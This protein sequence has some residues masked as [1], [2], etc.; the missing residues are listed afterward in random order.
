MKRSARLVAGSSVELM[1]HEPTSWI[2]SSL[3]FLSATSTL[4]APTAAKDEAAI[5]MLNQRMTD[6]TLKMS[7][8]ATL[9]LWSEDGISFLPGMPPVVGKVAIQ[10]FLEDVSAK[11]S[12]W[13]VVAQEDSCHDIRIAGPI[14]TEWCDTRQVTQPPKGKQTE[15]RGRMLLVLVKG[16]D[17]A[18]RIQR[19]MWQSS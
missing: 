7:T 9:D 2:L 15:N 3:V 4:A 17:G 18:W 14:A 13:K 6:A 1:A 16:T 19:E 8:S 5:Q 10:K 12:A 11:Y